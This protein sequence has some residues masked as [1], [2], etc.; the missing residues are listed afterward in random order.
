MLMQ[1]GVVDTDLA[2]LPLVWSIT[3]HRLRFLT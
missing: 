1:A 2:P 3:G